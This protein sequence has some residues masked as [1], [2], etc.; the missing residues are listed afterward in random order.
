M[1]EK[2]LLE[3]IEEE[4]LEE[5]REYLEKLAKFHK[6]AYIN[7]KKMMFAAK[8]IPFEARRNML[9]YRAALDENGKSYGFIKMIKVRDLS[10]K[11][12][13]AILKW[14]GFEYH[15][16]DS[17]LLHTIHEELIQKKWS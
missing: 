10:V 16:N 15:Q 9:E 4:E 14:A 6:Q 11:H 1:S 3:E 17:L 5:Q 7:R 13:N 12:M 2:D 8:R